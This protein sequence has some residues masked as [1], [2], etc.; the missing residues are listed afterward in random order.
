VSAITSGENS[1]PA[2]VTTSKVYDLNFA[3]TAKVT[4]VMVKVGQKVRAGQVLA[5]QDSSSLQTQLAAD[6]S[7][8]AADQALLNQLGAPEVTPAQRQQDSL[9][10]QQAQTALSN[11]QSDLA[12]ANSSGQANVAAAGAAITSAQTLETSDDSRYTQACPNGPVTP[13]A[14]LTGTAL[15]E[16]QAQ[17]THCQDLQ[18]TLDQDQTTVSQA[19]AQL[20]VVQAQSQQS[21]GTA[22]Q[23]VNTAQSALNTAEFQETLQASPT[24]TAAQAQAQASLNQAEAQLA[25]VEQSLQAASLI[26]PDGGVISEVYGEVGENLGP[27]GVQLYAAPAALPQNDPSGFSLFPSQPSVQGSDTTSSGSEPFLEIVG[28]SQQILAQVTQSQVS[29]VAVG[30]KATVTI[31]ALNENESGVITAVGLSP[32]RNNTA[33]TYDVTITLDRT[34]PGLLP[35]MS[36]TVRT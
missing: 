13:A 34:V 19:Q 15:Q 24:D 12:E 18:T 31:T 16:A 25:Q 29:E 32:T 20:P 23:S 11:A 14:D 10:V 5:T 33:V 26:A 3:D 28:G 2:V 36:A 27:D 35:G 6:K 7:S 1:F 30:R 9:Q 21:I 4:N 8:V 22:Q 17:F